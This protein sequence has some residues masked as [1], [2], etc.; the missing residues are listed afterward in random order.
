MW[1]QKGSGEQLRPI[2]APPCEVTGTSPTSVT[3]RVVVRNRI[4]RRPKEKGA[5]PGSNRIPLFTKRGSFNYFSC[6]FHSDLQ[7]QGYVIANYPIPLSFS[8]TPGIA[9]LRL[10]QHNQRHPLHLNTSGGPRTPSTGT[11]LFTARSG[12]ELIGSLSH[13][14]FP[15][16]SG[17]AA[18]HCP[19]TLSRSVLMDCVGHWFLIPLDVDTGDKYCVGPARLQAYFNQRCYWSPAPT[20]KK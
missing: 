6:K 2:R 11:P 9:A 12:W 10:K 18:P 16:V 17:M 3:K 8:S 5:V 4:L 15:A 19:V 1:K 20:S 14:T 7:C 13:R